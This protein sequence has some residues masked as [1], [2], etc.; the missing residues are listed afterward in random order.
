MDFVEKL[1]KSQGRSIVMVVVDRLT[2]YAHI[3]V[4]VH[5]FSV[6]VVAQQFLDNVYK[7]HGNP[8]SITSDHGVV[9]L[10]YPA[11]FHILYFP[12]DLAVTEV[13]TM[14]R[15][16]EDTIQILQHHLSKA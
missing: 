9:F 1:L 6:Q 3:M 13:D 7:L 2:K 12:K 4:L 10:S 8:A 15:L 14:L 5:P 11:P 16:R